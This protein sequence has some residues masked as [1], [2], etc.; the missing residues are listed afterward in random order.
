MGS[1]DLPT[2][3]ETCVEQYEERSSRVGLLEVATGVR[4]A[5]TITAESLDD[6]FAGVVTRYQAPLISFLYGMV[7]DREQAEDLAQDTLIKVY[8]AMSRRRPDQQFSP[9][10]LFRIARNTAVDAM[11]RKRLIAWLPFGPE[12]EPA[13]SGRSDFAGQLA[14]HELIHQVLA[15]LPS[16]YRQCLLLRSITGLSN[17][18][19]AEALGISVRNANT[20]LFRA[21]ERF[22]TIFTQLQES[23]PS[24]GLSAE[25]DA[26]ADAQAGSPR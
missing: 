11:R 18:E 24:P 1:T 21:R 23:L 20:T 10:W 6:S 2:E 9:G 25:G 5:T 19:I 15:Q 26:R 3:Y 8:E 13:M 22:R 4:T 7:G 17:T 14:D 16:R 12:H